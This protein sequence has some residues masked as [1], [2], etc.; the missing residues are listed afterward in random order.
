MVLRLGCL[1]VASHVPT[2]VL[3]KLIDGFYD[4][5]GCVNINMILEISVG[6][7]S[8]ADISRMMGRLVAWKALNLKWV[9]PV[10]LPQ[11]SGDAVI[12]CFEYI[13]WVGG[14]DQWG[15]RGFSDAVWYTVG[16]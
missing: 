14:V 13:D 2:N 5:L 11:V 12:R 6:R 15:N 10:V 9:C 1:L 16:R 4:C 7:G 8:P 3:D